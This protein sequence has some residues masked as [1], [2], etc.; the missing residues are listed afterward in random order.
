MATKAI[1]ISRERKELIAKYATA[2]VFL[3]GVIRPLLDAV[4]KN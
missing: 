2:A 4:I 3:Y 1:L